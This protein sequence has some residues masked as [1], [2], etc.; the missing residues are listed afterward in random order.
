MLCVSE[1]ISQ[2]LEK[3]GNLGILDD[4]QTM[5]EVQIKDFTFQVEWL[6]DNGFELCIER[7]E[8]LLEVISVS[9]Y[10]EFD[11]KDYE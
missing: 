5:G 6:L 7:L 11:P 4:V 2:Q 8:K 10:Y 9:V 1:R 3:S